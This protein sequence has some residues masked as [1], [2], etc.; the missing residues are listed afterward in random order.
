MDEEQVVTCYGIE[1][2]PS[3][4]AC[5]G[6]FYSN[7]D[8]QLKLLSWMD[9]N[10]LQRTNFSNILVNAPMALLCVGPES[11]MSL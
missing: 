4:E 2:E 1:F 6:M 3:Y 11:I 10:E 5:R 9:V 7:L 8:V